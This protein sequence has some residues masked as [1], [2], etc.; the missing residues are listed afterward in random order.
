MIDQLVTFVRQSAATI[1]HP[2]DAQA[3]D[4]PLDSS[5][6]VVEVGGY[7]GRWALQ[8]AERYRP[9]LVV[10]E[11]QPWAAEVCRAVLGDRATVVNAALGDHFGPMQMT[12]WE[13][14]GC[15]LAKPGGDRQV[16]M[17]EAAQ[18]FDQLGITT[19]DLLL[20]NIEGYEYTL[21]PYLLDQGILPRRLM[22]QLHGS[23]D[24][25]AAVFDRLAQAGYHIVWTYGAMLTAWE[26][27]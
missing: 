27:T 22:I 3:I 18:T 9:R 4:W 7:V 26:R 1:E 21:L 25:N 24:D 2:W 8:I 19:I 15:S 17:V 16:V 20:M 6:V 12:N 23:D 14:D 5:S 11:P 10:F 13:T